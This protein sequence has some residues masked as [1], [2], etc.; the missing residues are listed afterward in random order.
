MDLYTE[1]MK[2][3]SF[4]KITVNFKSHREFLYSGWEINQIA[5]SLNNVYYKN[6][7]INTLKS[8]LSNGT[9]PEDIYILNSSVK[10][11]KKYNFL[12]NGHMSLK[13]SQDV[14][15][16]YYMGSPIP[17]IP[18]ADILKIYYIFEIFRLL[19]KKCN[20]LGLTPPKRRYNLHN[21]FEYRDNITNAKSLKE[22]LKNEVYNCNSLLE[23][24]ELDEK[25]RKLFSSLEN[26]LKSFDNLFSDFELL[27]EFNKKY[28]SDIVEGLSLE[29]Y[30]S[31]NRYFTFFKRTF[32]RLERP[33][34]CVYKREEQQLYILCTDLISIKNFTEDN[35]RFFETKNISQNSPLTIAICIGLGFAPSLFKVGESLLSARKTIL[36]AKKDL[37][38]SK[39]EIAEIE[40]K[41][42]QKNEELDSL[43]K[44]IDDMKK[45]MA[46]IESNTTKNEVINK[47]KEVLINEGRNNSFANH[48]I[49]SLEERNNKNL[50]QTLQEKD[51]NIDNVTARE[52]EAS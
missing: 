47:A 11:G 35:Y 36:G 2:S 10:V 3:N 9:N 16:L 40:S 22:Y 15:N 39:K 18:N 27:N 44:E 26:S 13:R 1:K 41:I 17:L 7:L 5:N 30:T 38:K 23:T 20:S 19:Y 46:E 4:K 43:Q 29:K 42:A 33:F 51:L 34:I 12:K 8:L 32:D 31:L 14:T 25:A 48:I 28:S 45:V 24:K 50:E 6:E 52:N 49:E 37:L 21:L